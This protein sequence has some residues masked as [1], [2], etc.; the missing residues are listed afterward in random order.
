M[1]T[2]FG[3]WPVVTLIADG[4]SSGAVRDAILDMLRAALERG[5]PFAAA[6]DLTATADTE[7]DIA[8]RADRDPR[9]GEHAK[10]VK[11]MRAA[12]AS[13]CRGLAFV[14]G[15]RAPAAD[16]ASRFWGCPVIQ[17]ER[18]EDAVSWARESLR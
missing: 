11:E 16:A 7:E 12:L 13:Q 8:D 17:L 18:F 6:L 1:E 3:D 15:E 4:E 14:G 5:R 10:A 9:L 2:R